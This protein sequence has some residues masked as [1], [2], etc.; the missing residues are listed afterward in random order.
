M[1]TIKERQKELKIIGLYKGEIDGKEGALTKKAYRDL[2]NKYFFR[3]KDKDGI[4]GINTD[5]LLQCVYNVKISCTN[6]D[7]LKDK[8]YCRCKGKYC[9]GY[10]AIINLDLLRNLQAIRNKYGRT[11]VTSLLRCKEWNKLQGGVSD[12][13]H[14]KGKAV[15]YRGLYTVTL[16]KRKNVINYWFTLL[17]PSYSYCNG[18]Y[19]TPKKSGKK[20]SKGMG[21]S[22][23]GDVK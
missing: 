12:S 3:K 1:L 19:K 22:I 7:I 20:T 11:T 4:Y 14:L 2:Q 8:M 17:N 13:K 6:F 16:N 10:P 18:Y 21:T 15:D 5:K 23:H 9:T